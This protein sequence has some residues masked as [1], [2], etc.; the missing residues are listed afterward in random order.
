VKRLN[1][2]LKV[3]GMNLVLRGLSPHE[4]EKGWPIP[5][6]GESYIYV[7]SEEIACTRTC[8]CS[9]EYVTVVAIM[10]LQM[11]ICDCRRECATVAAM[12]C[13]WLHK[14]VCKRRCVTVV[15]NLCFWS[16]VVITVAPLH[17]LFIVVLKS[18]KQWLV[19]RWLLSS[20]TQALQ[21]CTYTNQP[22]SWK[23]PSSNLS[24]DWG[25][26]EPIKVG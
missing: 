23:Q 9:R 10:W 13:L 16:Q 6:S 4:R 7:Q 12:M 15:A 1:R 19:C 8:D 14:C 5:P 25:M 26:L 17:P 18:F 11:Q 2:K 22:H 3:M 21:E 24:Q 20:L